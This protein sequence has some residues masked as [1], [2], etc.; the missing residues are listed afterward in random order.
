MFYADACMSHLEMEVRKVE[1]E[2]TKLSDEVGALT[3]FFSNGRILLFVLTS[4]SV[5]ENNL[6]IGYYILFRI[7]Y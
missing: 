6:L 5:V 7:S 2:K 4:V 3:E 1:E